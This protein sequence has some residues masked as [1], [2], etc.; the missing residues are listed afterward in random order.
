MWKEFEALTD[1]CLNVKILD[2]AGGGGG[3]GVVGVICMATDE[4]YVFV[5][6]VLACVVVC[7]RRKEMK[8]KII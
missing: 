8:A 1:P 3:R 2:G 6:R 7:D 4:L 5:F